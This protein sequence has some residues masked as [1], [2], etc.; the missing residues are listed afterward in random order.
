MAGFFKDR[1]NAND[2]AKALFTFQET[3]E[4]QAR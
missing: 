1:K 3:W 4:C 2:Y